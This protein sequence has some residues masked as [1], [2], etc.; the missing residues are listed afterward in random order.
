MTRAWLLANDLK[1]ISDCTGGRI[2]DAVRYCQSELQRF[3]DMANNLQTVLYKAIVT[4]K[5]DLEADWAIGLRGNGYDL[6]TMA[7][8]CEYAGLMKVGFSGKK[9]K[10][11]RSDIIKPFD[12][13]LLTAFKPF[14]RS[15]KKLPCIVFKKRR[16]PNNQYGN[17]SEVKWFVGTC[18]EDNAANQI[19][20][21]LK[22]DPNRPTDMKTLTFAHPVRPRTLKRERMCEVCR[23]LFTEP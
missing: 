9:G 4:L 2:G 10:R 1:Q 7:A 13:L 16:K 11:R 5:S 8:G 22:G 14:N 20:Y 12:D 15:N 18:A 3:L 6:P 19:L 21:G 23:T 17:T